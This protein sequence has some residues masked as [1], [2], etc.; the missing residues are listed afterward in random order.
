MTATFVNR[1]FSF[2]FPESSITAPEI[3]AFIKKGRNPFSR[4]LPYL[5]YD[6]EKGIYHTPDGSVGFMFLCTPLWGEIEEARRN[7]KAIVLDLPEHAVLSFHL[8]SD[9]RVE[10]ILSSYVELKKEGNK[11]LVDAIA[12]DYA[13]YLKKCTSRGIPHLLGTPLRRFLLVVSVKLPP[14]TSEDFLKNYRQSLLEQLRHFGPSVLEPTAFIR[15]FFRIFNS[16]YA[17]LFWDTLRPIRNQLL[18]SD[19]EIEFK[20]NRVRIGKRLWACVGVKGLPPEFD[21]SILADLVGP[22]EGA[23]SDSQQILSHFIFTTVVYR[24]PGLHGALIKK[25]GLFFNQ[26]KGEAHKS[27]IGRLIGDYAQEHSEAAEEIERGERFFYIFPLFWI[28]DTDEKRLATSV[29]R[30]RNL[31]EG[32]GFLTQEERGILPVLF[33]MGLPLGFSLKGKE[34]DALDRHFIGKADLAASLLPAVSDIS[35]TET[36][37]CIFISRKGQIIP[38]DPWSRGVQNKNIMVVGATGGGKS[39]NMNV[40][41]Y[42]LY[43]SGA[44]V[45]VIDLGY[46]YEKLCRVLGGTFIDFDDEHPLCLNPFTY[47]SGANQDE[48]NGAL[49]SIKD[50]ILTMIF[51][52]DRKSMTKDHETLIR[53]AVQYVW[54]QQG[55]DSNIGMVYE[56]LATFPAYADVEDI[57]ELP[58]GASP[59]EKKRKAVEN[60]C[61][62]DL[63]NEAQRMAYALKPWVED[64][65][66]AR[67]FIGKANVDLTSS[68]FIVLELERLRRVEPLLRVVGQAIITAASA[69]LYLSERGRRKL[70]LF[71]ECGVLL[72][73]NPALK[74]TVEE[75]YRRA[76]KYNGAVVT[77]FQSAMDLS[78][79]KDAGHVIVGNSSYHFYLPDSQFDQ[80]AKAG[81]V[82]DDKYLA[83]LARS[84]TLVKPR[85]SEMVLKSPFGTGVVR[86][87]LN[88]ELYYL[89]TTD[90]EEWKRIDEIVKERVKEGEE[91]NRAL[92]YAI[93]KLGKERDEAFE[94]TYSS[95]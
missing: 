28:F 17:E 18:T 70:F 29:Q 75:M 19:T 79:L 73:E 11:P 5:A 82:D 54:S 39:V 7:L 46:S 87:V 36:P 43:A 89:T 53:Q 24:D 9:D 26:L 4:Y 92:V 10:D 83:T 56:W 12:R 72:K 86:T 30:V 71:E 52:N 13:E 58:E 22:S 64:G 32:R 88:G 15:L 81:I 55:R 44:L 41:V 14:D 16:R 45:R 91:K 57:C 49:D 31:F 66:Y 74:N 33:L 69:S 62:V 37:S 94:K 2:V 25:A 27:I 50:L 77:V 90:P 23:H 8:I 63:K 60:A 80:A 40:L 1:L 65:P 93:R 67:W 20:W 42:S 95:F 78:Y 21:S 6:P 84:V 85:Y 59:E 76:R 34:I 68:D 35:G 3:R 38:F 61:L 51:M 48:I 47:V